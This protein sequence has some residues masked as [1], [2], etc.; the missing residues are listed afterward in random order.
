MTE[1]PQPATILPDPPKKAAATPHP[2]HDFRVAAEKILARSGA[3]PLDML[4][5]LLDKLDP[6][7][8]AECNNKIEKKRRGRPRK[9]AAL[10]DEGMTSSNERLSLICT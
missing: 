10:D 6:A 4:G 1:P 5:D 9:Y 2:A 3:V 7:I 8:Y